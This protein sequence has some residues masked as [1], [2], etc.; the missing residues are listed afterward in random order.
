MAGHAM[1]RSNNCTQIIRFFKI[2]PAGRRQSG[3]VPLG[4][5]RIA[6]GQG[7]PEGDIAFGVPQPA[8]CL[9]GSQPAQGQGVLLAFMVG[10]AP[11]E[12]PPFQAGVLAC[13]FQG[14]AGPRQFGLPSAAACPARRVEQAYAI[15]QHGVIRM[16]VQHFPCVKCI[17]IP[18]CAFLG[19]I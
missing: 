11:Q 3:G 8:A 17:D 12:I 5:L 18:M 13:P 9:L 10:D 19:K 4:G 1:L 15:E 6:L 14:G 7:Q 16:A 2:I